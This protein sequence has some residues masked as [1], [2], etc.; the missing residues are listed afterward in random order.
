M[1]HTAL[2]PAWSK[3]GTKHS[4]AKGLQGKYERHQVA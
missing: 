1:E 3:L 4:K 2:D